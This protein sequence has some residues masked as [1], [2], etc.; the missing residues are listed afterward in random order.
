[1][2]NTELCRPCGKT[3]H[4]VSCEKQIKSDKNLLITGEKEIWTL[5]NILRFNKEYEDHLNSDVHQNTEQEQQSKIRMKGN[6]CDRSVSRV[7]GKKRK[8]SIRHKRSVKNRDQRT[9]LTESP[10][11]S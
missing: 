3:F 2:D 1:M 10:N 4:L 5:Q 11:R 7:F 8:K 6:L 9:H